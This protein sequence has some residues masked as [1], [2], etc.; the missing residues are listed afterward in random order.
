MGISGA[1]VAESLTA[2]GFSVTLIDRRGPMLGSTPAST[3]LVQYEIDEPLT[4]LTRSLGRGR[5]EQAW[6]R[7][8]LAVLNLSARIDE[9]GISCGK[10]SR[11]ALLLAGND[12]GAGGL[13]A[14]AEARRAAG[15]YAE[16][17]TRARLRERF[18]IEREGAILSPGN[19]ALD[20]RKLTAG[21]LLCAI[22]RG[23]KCHAPAEATTIEASHDR[24]T[25]ATAD[26]PVISAVHVVL[27][28][29]YELAELVPA[30]AHAVI[31]TWAIATRPQPRALW[32]EEALIW[33]SSD[34]YL[35]LRTTSDGRISCGGEDEEFSD[36]DARDALIPAKTARLSAKLGRLFPEVDARPE[37]A[38]AGALGTTRTGLPLIGKLPGY[39][40]VHAVMGY[41]GNGITFSRIAAEIVCA[42]FSGATDTDAARFA[43]EG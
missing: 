43:F 17:L 5:S 32:P 14:E 40:R 23:A 20:P 27:A 16:Y 42:D 13:R 9:L 33:E 6:R 39:P 10:V 26:G 31:S 3:A 25:V 37:F 18:G 41:G 38:W 34:P 22:E 1:M 15:L 35:Y 29:G 4:R 24:V 12:L 36:E 21:L 28:T 11:S 8:R 7:S 2:A 19:L 30:K